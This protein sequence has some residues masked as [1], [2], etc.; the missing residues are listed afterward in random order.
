MNSS[1]SAKELRMAAA[2][3]E[4]RMLAELSP[5]ETPPHDF[6]EAFA[7]KMEPL[8]K[9][10]GRR[11][12]T[13]QVMRTVAAS[14][15]LI[16]LCGVIWAATNAEARVAVQRWFKFTWNNIITYQF[17]E[18]W[19]G[20]LPTYRPTW[21]PD[22]YR[23]AGIFDTGK[24]CDITYEDENGNL[25]FFYYQAMDD[26]SELGF[27]I[28]NEDEVRHESVLIKGLPGDFYICFTGNEQ[29]CLIWMDEKN[30]L[31]FG[32]DSYLESDVILQIAESVS[33]FRNPK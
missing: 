31:V 27:V 23:E 9:A 30:G 19:T 5:D 8:L 21:L 33:K 12:K 20:K 7:A 32:V 16:I 11:E 10:S 13:R 6:S 29:S 4:R 1:F 25:I 18:E 3:A 2:E 22:G 15:A 17:T 26:G 28:L 24:L 14:I